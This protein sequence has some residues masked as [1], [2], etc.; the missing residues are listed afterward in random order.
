MGDMHLNIR[1]AYKDSLVR[2]GHTQ[3]V[4]QLE[5]LDALAEIEQRIAERGL[6]F[7]LGRLLRAPRHPVKGLYL[8][9]TV[10]RGKT[11]L[12]DLFFE[13]LRQPQKKR[14]HFHHMMRDVHE[15]LKKL[16][17]TRDPVDAVAAEIARDT[18]VLCFDEF[19][20]SDIADAMLLA[21]L[22]D[23]LFRRGVTLVATSNVAPDDLYRD[24]LQRQQF[25]PAIRLLQEHTRVLQIGDGQDYRLR[26]LERSGTYHCPANEAAHRHLLRYF[27]AI[28]PVHCAADSTLT[29]LGR[30]IAA[31]FAGEGIAWF[32]F[33]A[34]C[35]G[36][37]SQDDYIEIARCYSTVIISGVP[38]FNAQMN[39]QA[40]RFIALVDE[41]YD[42]KVKLLVSAAAPIDRLYAAGRLQSEF[43]RTRSRLTEMQSRQYLG[44]PHLG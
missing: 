40:R 27:A 20:V 15:R 30:N 42:R 8:W 25:L 21:R 24:G 12:M 13:S 36:P 2:L 22:L 29:I 18:R 11:F 4:A 16:G 10:G 1:E 19:Y 44:A 37:R 3:D 26:F 31:R 33:T 39:D 6:P 5:V 14:V 34:I 38:V 17:G 23:G 7:W 32:D 43:A 35:D 41:F 9:G 28:S